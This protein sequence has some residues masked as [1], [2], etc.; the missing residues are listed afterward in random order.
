MALDPGAARLAALTMEPE[1]LERILRCIPMSSAG[2]AIG[3]AS[4]LLQT[5]A[6]I[7]RSLPS[8]CDDLVRHLGP[9][10]REFWRDM[11]LRL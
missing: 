5:I 9:G 1:V 6:I 10:N 11:V 7:C 8:D 2:H 4:A 3:D